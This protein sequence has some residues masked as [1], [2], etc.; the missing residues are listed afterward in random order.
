MP[1]SG[2]TTTNKT[3][4]IRGQVATSDFTWNPQNFAGFY[5][6]IKNDLGTETLST[7]L[8]DKKLSGDSPY[9]VKYE[10]TAQFKEFKFENWGDYAQIGFLGEKYFAG[11]MW[12]DDAAKNI[13]FKESVDENSLSS[14]QLEK[15]LVDDD[16]E[17]TV[18]SGTPLKLAEGYELVIKLID[19]NGM[20]LELAKDGSVV[21]S[22]VIS[23]SKEGATEIDKTY[24]YKNPV[25]GDQMNLVT[26]GVHFKNALNIQNQTV[27]TIDGI[28]QISAEA[29]EVKADTQYDKMSITSVDA[30]AGTITMENKDNAITLSKNKDTAL[31]GGI[32]IKTADNDTLRYYIYSE[33]ECG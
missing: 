30:N 31:M 9:G 10:T 20:Y 19:T 27:A 6:D 5:Y 24:W 25:V 4:E 26:I 11:Y 7:T 21:D 3:C 28:W 33:C 1:I 29:T 23:P 14:E 32:S 12:S 16:V 13:F 17:R 22:R 2:Q 18:T 15:I 8:T